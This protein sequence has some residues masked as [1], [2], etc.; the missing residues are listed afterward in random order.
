MENINSELDQRA[1]QQ[2]AHTLD[3]STAQHSTA[4]HST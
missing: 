1:D 4:Q 3:N 2:T